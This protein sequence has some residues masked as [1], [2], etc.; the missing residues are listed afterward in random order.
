MH[1]AE[2]AFDRLFRTHETTSQE[3]SNVGKKLD[4]L[5]ELL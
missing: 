2:E 5:I 4:K 1:V 3:L